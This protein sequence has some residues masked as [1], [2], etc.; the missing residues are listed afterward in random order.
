MH[1]AVDADQALAQPC[2][3][4]EAQDDVRVTIVTMSRVIPRL[5]VP[6]KY[7]ATLQ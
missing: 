5:G 4:L 3:R 2:A 6:I 1:C 7:P